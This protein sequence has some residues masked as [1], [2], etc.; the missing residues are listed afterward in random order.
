MGVADLIPPRAPECYY[1]LHSKNN[2]GG[3]MHHLNLFDAVYLAMVFACFLIRTPLEIRNRRIRTTEM[4]EGALGKFLLMLV[5]T[6]SATMPLLYFVTHWFDFASYDVPPVAGAIGIALA[7][8]GIYLFWRSHRDLG[9]QFSPLLEVKEGHA[10]V[11][12]GV[13]RRI[14]HPMYTALFM[15]SAAQAF[16]IGNAV[17]GPAFLLAF[18]LLYVTRVDNEEAMMLAHFGPAYADYT[19]R[20]HRLLPSLRR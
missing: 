13:Y 18:W 5:F 7:V 2:K 1:L 3:R 8:P 17:V 16:L 14:R 11:C 20:T 6:G 9:R 10:L 19:R 12:D 4:R 15:V